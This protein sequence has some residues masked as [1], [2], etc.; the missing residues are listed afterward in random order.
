MFVPSIPFI[1]THERYDTSALGWVYH[2]RVRT[3]RVPTYPRGY[4]EGTDTLRIGYKKLARQSIEN[5]ESN[6]ESNLFFRFI[7]AHMFDACANKSAES[8]SRLEWESSLGT[9][10]C[11][12]GIFCFSA[13]PNGPARKRQPHKLQSTQNENNL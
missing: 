7:D 6:R 10:R 3:V 2:W 1:R 12:N 5:R 13:K 9:L 11:W 4:E 8:M